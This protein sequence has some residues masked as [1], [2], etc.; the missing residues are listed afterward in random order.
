MKKLTIVAIGILCAIAFSTAASADA[1]MG[2]VTKIDDQAGTVTLSNG[3][4][5]VLLGSLPSMIMVGDLVNVTFTTDQSG[6][7]TASNVEEA[8]PAYQ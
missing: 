7:L 5:Y 6:Q 3:K 2:T 8:F 1:A 4:T